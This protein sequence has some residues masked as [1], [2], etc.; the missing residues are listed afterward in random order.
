MYIGGIGSDGLP[1]PALGDRRQLRRRGDQ[2]LRQAR[3]RS[4]STRTARA[5]PSRTTAAAS[6]STS[7]R[8]TRSPRSSS[9]SRRCTPAASS[10]ASNYKASGG[11]H[12]VGASVVNALSKKLVATVQARRRRVAAGVRARRR[13]GQARRRSAPARGTAPPSTS[14]PTRRSS[15]RTRVRPGDHPRAPR[16][17]SYLHRGLKILFSDEPTDEGRV[18]QHRAGH[19]RLPAE[20]DRRARHKPIARAR[21]S[22]ARRRTASRI[23]V[24]LQWT[25][26]TDEHVR[27]YVN[28]IPTAAAARTRTASTAVVKAVRNYIE[29][30]ELA[31]R[32]VT[33]TAE[34]IR[35][36]IVAS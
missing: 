29:T 18:F 28:G 1:P 14:G 10:S 23:E 36:G 24:A 33:L 9:S 6:P 12:G 2:R 4:R 34:D 19:R 3:S 25:E 15:P 13:A 7:T 8:S 32:G 22:P 16:G 17:E 26:A 20:A 21:P 27:C 31:P 30:H 11:L 5:S 35:E